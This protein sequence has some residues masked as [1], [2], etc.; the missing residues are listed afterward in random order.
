MY[1]PLQRLTRTDIDRDRSFRGHLC[2]ITSLAF[3]H[4]LLP[5]QDLLS[6]DDGRELELAVDAHLLQR[7]RV[8]DGRSRNMG[9]ALLHVFVV[10]DGASLYR[11][12]CANAVDTFDLSSVYTRIY[13]NSQ[14]ERWQNT[15]LLMTYTLCIRQTM[16]DV[17]TASETY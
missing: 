6:V 7:L 16:I 3:H 15:L 17:S 13:H 10:S 5:R 12:V 1:L 14:D 2:C 11:Y 4:Q 9:V 8:P